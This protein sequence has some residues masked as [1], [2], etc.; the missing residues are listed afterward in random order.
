MGKIIRTMTNK[1]EKITQIEYEHLAEYKQAME[2]AHNKIAELTLKNSRKNTKWC[3]VILCVT[4]LSTVL[5]AYGY[6]HVGIFSSGDSI[7]SLRNDV[8]KVKSENKR[9]IEWFKKNYLDK[10]P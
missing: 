6:H 3:V 8:E 10:K 9:M 5:T 1:T 4:L 7:T 2:M